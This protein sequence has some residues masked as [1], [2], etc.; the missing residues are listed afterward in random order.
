MRE[1]SYLNL[2]RALLDLERSQL[3]DR[4]HWRTYLFQ[5]QL[6]RGK[7]SSRSSPMRALSRCETLFREWSVYRSTEA[8]PGCLGSVARESWSACCMSNSERCYPWSQLTSTNQAWWGL[9]APWPSHHLKS[10][11][12][13]SLSRQGSPGR[14]QRPPQATSTA[15]CSA[16]SLWGAGIC[17]APWTRLVVATLRASR[18]L[19]G[20]SACDS[21]G[22]QRSF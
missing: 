5:C 1:T 2:Y 4:A 14:S 21:C 20:T 10:S 12:P 18:I 9:R 8:L 13:S 7:V 16:R 11:S 17:S 3:L 15:L 22:F 6:A 19:R